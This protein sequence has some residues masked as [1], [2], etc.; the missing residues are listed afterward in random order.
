[1]KNSR[2][3]LTQTIVGGCWGESEKVLLSVKINLKLG[4][5]WSL[6]LENISK[7]EKQM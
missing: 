3:H 5:N 7:V 6:K 4:I 2:W 1:M